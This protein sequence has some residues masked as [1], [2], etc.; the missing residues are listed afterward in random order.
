MIAPAGMVHCNMADW[1]RFLQSQLRGLRG[2]TTEIVGPA[3]FDALRTTPEG[4]D[5]ALGWVVRRQPNG[6]TTFYHHGSNRRFTAEVWLV[7]GDDWGMI[8]ITN[9]GSTI[10]NRLLVV[11]DEAMFNRRSS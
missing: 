8:T 10:A 3:S 6:A 4:S 5:Y 9:L 2:S 7:P 1:V 11:V